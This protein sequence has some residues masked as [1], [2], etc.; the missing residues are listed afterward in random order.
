MSD[1]ERFSG[2]KSEYIFNPI[3]DYKDG[4][5]TRP[6]DLVCQ[7][8]ELLPHT[9]GPK[10]GQ[11]IK[12]DPWQ[13]FIVMSIF[14]WVRRSDNTRRFRRVY[15]EVP[16]GNAKSTLAAAIAL[17]ML[18]ADGEAGA[19]VYSL[20]TT[21]EQ[22]KIVFGVAQ[23]MVR[24]SAGLRQKFGIELAAHSIYQMSTG[25]VFKALSSRDDSLDGKNTHLGCIDELHAHRTRAIYDVIETSTGKRN[26]SLLLTIT[27]AGFDRSGICYEVRSYVRSVLDG[28]VNDD[29]QFGII[30]GIDQGDDWTS[31]E[32]L[33]KANPSWG[34]AVRPEVVVALQKKA[35]QVPSAVNNFLT[36]HLDE[37]VSSHVS[38]MDMRAWDGCANP[39]LRIEDFARQPCWIGLD[40]A[41][42][43]DVAAMVMIFKLDGGKVAIFGRFYLPE[44]AID[45][46]G[47]AQYEGWRREG[48]LTVT[49]GNVLDFE[50]I[51][52]DLIDARGKFDV[53]AVAYDPF[54]AMQLATEM[55]ADGL[56][57]V[58]V[59]ATVRNFSE[60]M[61]QLDALVRQGLL[62]HDGDPILGWMASNVVAHT[63]AKD[64]IYPRKERPENKIDGIVAAIMALSRAL[65]EEEPNVIGPDYQIMVC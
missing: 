23:Q 32:A 36:K 58:E 49:T 10:A 27:T 26:N 1:L 22:A 29:S 38:W 19:E 51:K 35:M 17:Y 34:C 57:M 28:K 62:V 6:G 59:G 40:L 48:R 54:Q 21:S 25:S 45:L 53:R 4:Y 41:S 64:N 13:V 24:K 7:F 52:A 44:T 14:G 18:A 2:D 8:I 12:L 65:T 43:I 39:D 56:P 3:I 55:L 9:K 31:L 50:W 42:K 47:N 20:A 46:S 33:K 60:P 16:R 5:R 37:W 15:I 30:Y 11:L 63:D 61:K